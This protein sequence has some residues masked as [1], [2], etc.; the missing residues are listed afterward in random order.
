MK[1]YLI[2]FTL[3]LALLAVSDVLFGQS[4]KVNTDESKI[5]WIGRK[6]AGEHKGY[7][8]LREG[9]LL[10]ENNELK[11]GSFVLDM[12]SIED[13]DL[14]NE[15]MKAKLLNHLK[16]DD[17]FDVQKYPTARYVITGVTRINNG[18]KEKRNATHRIDGNLTM[19]GV[20][21]KVS[22]D[23]SINMLNGKVAANT[24]SFKINRTDWGV[25]YQSKSIFSN[26]VDE[27]IH[28][29]IEL[30]IDLVSN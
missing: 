15:S 10:V 21:K 25:N 23:A 26:L 5:N 29:D 6:P 16:S 22:F 20:T 28:D 24:P 8:K 11:G 27:F 13:L 19:K 12:K 7:V 17:F 3:T 4:V 30:T 2:G 18:E 1:R 14:K 9:E